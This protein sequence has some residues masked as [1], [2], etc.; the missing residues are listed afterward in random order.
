MTRRILNSILILTFSAALAGAAE[1]TNAPASLDWSSFESI[2]QKNIFDPSRSGR[3]GRSSRPKPAVVRVFTFHGIVD[4]I[5]FFTGDGTPGKGYVK[6][7]DTINGFKVMKIS[8][9]T[10]YTDT[11]QITLTDPSGA[12][13]VLNEDQSMR[14]EEEG[15]WEKSDQPAPVSTA[16]AVTDTSSPS[17]QSTAPAAPE[18]AGASDILAR[19]RARKK[20]QEQ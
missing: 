13:V 17:D 9:P 20:Q 6:V 19:L 4:D 12:I 5:A 18:S 11:P 14:R 10:H 1:E 2:A 3:S 15:P 16:G 7:G 8:G